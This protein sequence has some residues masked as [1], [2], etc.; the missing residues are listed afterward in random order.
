MRP[1][2]DSGPSGRECGPER[3]PGRAVLPPHAHAKPWA[4]HPAKR[5]AW[6]PA[7]PWAWHPAIQKHARK[8]RTSRDGRD[9]RYVWATF[10]SSTARFE[11]S[12]RDAL[13][14]VLPPSEPP[15]PG[16]RPATN[17]PYPIR[18]GR[19]GTGLGDSKTPSQLCTFF[20]IIPPHAIY[21]QN[22]RRDPAGHGRERKTTQQGINRGAERASP[23]HIVVAAVHP[24][25]SELP[26]IYPEVSAPAAV[27]CQPGCAETV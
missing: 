13:D 4:W 15:P 12:S 3:I 23:F 24:C 10:T 25:V 26:A 17:C 1:G 9:Q 8:M 16:P 20:F 6:H 14:M 18:F 11:R 7:K 27:R 19:F 21:T 2:K 5:W 22:H